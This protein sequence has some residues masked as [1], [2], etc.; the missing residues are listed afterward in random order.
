[1]PPRSPKMASPPTSPKQ[2]R[3][4][5]G[6]IQETYHKLVR[7]HS[8]SPSRQSVGVPESNDLPISPKPSQQP[9][10][11][12]ST[13]GGYLSPPPTE[14]ATIPRHSQDITHSSLGN[15]ISSGVRGAFEALHQ[16]TRLFPPLQSAVSAFISCLDVLEVYYQIDLI[17]GHHP[18]YGFRLDPGKAS[19]RI[20][21]SC[22]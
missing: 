19:N 20:H 2:K 13:A 21:K 8:R 7:S 11:R 17:Y 18:N 22:V 14:V 6:Y 3:G 16:G 4:V 10:Q 9:S 12:A 15:A 5:R 1:M